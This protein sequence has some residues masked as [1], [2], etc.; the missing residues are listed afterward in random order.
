MEVI[1]PCEVRENVNFVSTSHLRFRVNATEGGQE[2]TRTKYITFV[3]YFAPQLGS[4]TTP[5]CTKFRSSLLE[6]KNFLLLRNC[7]I[8][9]H[10]ALPFNV[11]EGKFSVLHEALKRLL[12]I[13]AVI[14]NLLSIIRT[15]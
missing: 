4:K 2:R 8:S 15:Y 11:S 3:A 14:E 9:F 10:A 5:L 7:C 12:E 6:I 13:N 1:Q